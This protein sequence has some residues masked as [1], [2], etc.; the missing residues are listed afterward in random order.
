MSV[1]I[2]AERRVAGRVLQ[3]AVVPDGH[4]AADGEEERVAA[5]QDVPVLRCHQEAAGRLHDGSA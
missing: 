5:G 2:V 3:P 1:H 4:H